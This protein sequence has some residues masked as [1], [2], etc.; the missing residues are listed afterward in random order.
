MTTILTTT[1]ISLF[2][3]T[4]RKYDIKEST[5]DQM[6]QYLRM[7]PEHASAEVNSLIQIVKSDDHLVFLCTETPNAQGCA[8]LLK[9]FFTN[10]D[11]KHID[12]VE[13]QFQE[14]EEHIETQG[15]RNLVNALISEIDKAQRKNQEIVINATAGFKA[16][17][18]YNTMIGMI[19]HVPV[20]YMYETFKKIVTFTPI[21]L[22][23]DTSLFLSNDS[24]FRWLDSQP[25][26]QQEVEIRLKGL[27]DKE[28]IE[29]LLTSP[30]TNGEV[31]LSPMGEALRRRF[32]R[33]TEETF[34]A[35]WPPVAEIETEDKIS[36]SLQSIKHHFPRGTLAICKKIA[37]LPWV[38][39]IIGGNF[40]NTLRTDIKGINEDGTIRLLWADN[41]KATN[42][43]VQTTAQGRAQTRKIEVKIRELL[44]IN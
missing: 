9:E 41:E 3:N 24:F 38:L 17:I 10:R 19:Y 8:N 32:E 31:F 30:D 36:Q 11:F 25:R 15:L 29:A 5:D 23:W 18:V 43:V 28:R 2:L 6:R 1:G 13:L 35:P 16:Q 37:Q 42:L 21:A 44:E 34:S 27:Y 4:N 12:I 22:D 14:K 26:S 33:E 40:E 39:A 7:E 20:K